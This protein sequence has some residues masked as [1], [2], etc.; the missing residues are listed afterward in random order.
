[1]VRDTHPTATPTPQQ[2]RLIL[3]GIGQVL[4]QPEGEMCVVVFTALSHLN[5]SIL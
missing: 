4:V 2:L 1:M 3:T 5:F